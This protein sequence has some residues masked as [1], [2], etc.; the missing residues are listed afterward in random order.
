VVGDSGAGK[1]TL[2]RGLI[3]VMGGEQVVRINADDYHRYARRERE[4]LGVTPPPGSAGPGS[5]CA[6]ARSAT[7]GNTLAGIATGLRTTG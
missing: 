6:T 1:T 7:V 2:T 5:S 4:Q 3:R